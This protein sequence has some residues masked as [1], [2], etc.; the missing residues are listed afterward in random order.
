MDGRGRRSSAETDNFSIV[1][2]RSL[3]SLTAG[4]TVWWIEETLLRLYAHTVP[5]S[6]ILLPPFRMR[7]TTFAVRCRN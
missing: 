4:G 3:S 2:V 5:P 6:L 1:L 7:L